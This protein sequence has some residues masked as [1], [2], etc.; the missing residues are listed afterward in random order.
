MDKRI[1]LIIGVIICLGLVVDQEVNKTLDK[2]KLDTIKSEL[3]KSKIEI[4]ISNFEWEGY[5]CT[6]RIYLSGL[7]DEDYRINRYKCTK[8]N[9]DGNCIEKA[10]RTEKELR[11]E[12][13]NRVIDKLD[14]YYDEITKSKA[15]KQ[16]GI[17]EI[18]WINY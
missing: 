15:I 1:F 9:K 12:I 17:L 14:N 18:K 4:S 11:D 2:S 7:I 5:T 10:E 8:Y 13:N 3:G 16:G 6:A